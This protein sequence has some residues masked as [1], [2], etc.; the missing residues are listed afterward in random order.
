VFL[1]NYFY[2]KSGRN[3]WVA[4]IFHAVANVSNELFAADPDTKIIQT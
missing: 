2:L 3:I 1:I 4:I